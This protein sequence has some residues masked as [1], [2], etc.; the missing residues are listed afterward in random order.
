M[1]KLFI[2]NSLFVVFYISQA[3]NNFG[4]I[5]VCS[6]LFCK[7]V[8]INPRTYNLVPFSVYFT[9]VSMPLI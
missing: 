9:R 7:L 4:G 8:V 3:G 2:T 5:F 1:P 6:L